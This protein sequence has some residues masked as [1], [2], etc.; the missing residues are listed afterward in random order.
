M[1]DKE[2]AMRL[3]RR[4]IDHNFY[5]YP[6]FKQDP[7][8]ASLREEPEYS[9]VMEAARARHEADSSSRGATCVSVLPKKLALNGKAV[10]KSSVRSS[11]SDVSYLARGS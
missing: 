10:A 11:G 9:K 5:C 7:L 1:S 8:L 3:L 6:Y 2:S 4:S